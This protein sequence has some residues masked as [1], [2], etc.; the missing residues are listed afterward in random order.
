[1]PL[2]RTALGSSYTKDHYERFLRKFLDF[3]ELDADS[4]VA[5]AKSDPKWT[6]RKI[7]EYFLLI[8]ER[9]QKGEIRQNSVRNFSK[10]LRLF[11]D[12]NDLTFINWRKLRRILPSREVPA[13]DRIPTI[14]EIK[15]LCEYPDRRMKFVI[16]SMISG[17]FRSGA[18]DYLNKEHLEPIEE[19]GKIITAR[20]K[21]Y[22][23]QPEQYFTFISG[24][25]YLEI[26]KYFQFRESQGERLTGKS[27]I[28]RDLIRGDKGGFGEPHLP[29]RLKSTG[30]RSLIDQALKTQ[31][32]RQKLPKG[33]KRHEA[34]EL[35]QFR[36]FHETQC[37]RAGMNI[38]HIKML[39]GDRIGLETNYYRPSDQDLLNDYKKAI[40][41]LTVFDNTT[42]PISED[43]E[44][45][46]QRIAQ[47]EAEKEADKLKYAESLKGLDERLKRIEEENR[48]G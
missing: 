46:K 14:D 25:A 38:I 5:K 19:D 42:L 28:L 33:E 37:I 40:P 13:Q 26:Q 4:F 45:L 24:E 16:L 18:W 3:V 31:G 34:K 23:G 8:N 10:P 47:L 9:V 22:A 41:Y 35:H 11:T 21:I 30:L 15:R 44:A 39:R 17:G 48:K 20:L 6:E 36:K 32:I 2:F 43:I 29:K 1:M 12:M 27:P 7:V